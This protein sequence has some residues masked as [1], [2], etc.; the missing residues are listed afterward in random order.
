MK[1][2]QY[3]LILSVIV[4]GEASAAGSL[5]V[6]IDSPN[7]RRLI[8]AIPRFN[9]KLSQDR[10]VQDM[11]QQGATELARMLVFSG[12]FNAMDESGFKD[13][14]PKLKANV[15]KGD[16]K[17]LE[18]IALTEW[19]GIGVESLTVA[20]LSK[21]GS[22]YTVTFRTADIIRGELVVGTK[23]TSVKKDE[24]MAVIRR[25]ADKILK[26]Y[27]GK[28]GIFSSRLVFVGRASK[29]A[30]KQ[31]YIAAFDGSGAYPITKENCPHLSP[32]W[33]PDGRYITYTS[34]EDGNPDLFIYDTVTSKKRKLSGYK[35]LNSGS[36]WSKSGK[37]L[38][39]SGSVAGDTDIYTISPSGGNRT[40]LIK[41][42]GLDAEPAISPDGKW[43]AFVSG[44]FG[45]PHIFR[46][47]L[48][49]D[50]DTSVK[51]LDDKRLT[52]AGWYN[53]TPA[54]SPES[55]KIAFAGY[56]KDIDR[57][58]LFM[59]NPDGTNMERLTLRAGDNERPA[60]SPNGQLLIFQS[61][62][63]PGQNVKDTFKIW[64]MNRDGSGQRVLETGIYEV[65]QPQWSVNLDN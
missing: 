52:F 12:Y 1:L 25:Y 9:T 46:A 15:G 30:Q 44:R 35:G 36:N 4:S 32:T 39:F 21:E 42:A 6:N 54:W 38:A 19:R 55:D 65:Q 45:N 14:L 7:F 2:L 48:K 33:S 58:D 26:A 51:V 59:M 20:E 29:K 28:A 34:Y 53:A 60:W 11:A 50:G 56:D 62:R 17:G 10:D 22:T 5:S 61:N 47:S 49:W 16:P 57:F 40:L 63:V 64:I 31:I 43:L 3:L 41:G 18:G 24:Y 37:L 8:T 23:Y 27:T 13:L